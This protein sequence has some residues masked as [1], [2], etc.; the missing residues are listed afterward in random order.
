MNDSRTSLA[1]NE[2]ARR[3]LE[4]DTG[5][6]WPR[7]AFLA[8]ASPQDWLCSCGRRRTATIADAVDSVS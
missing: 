7:G 4:D 6:C 5:M 1:L 3:R 8:E 2:I